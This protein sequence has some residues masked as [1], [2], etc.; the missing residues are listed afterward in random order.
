MTGDLVLALLR[1]SA[2]DIAIGVYLVAALLATAVS[3][4]GLVLESVL[5]PASTP[6]SPASP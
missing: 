3:T 6:T 5:R 4:L 2:V 1:G